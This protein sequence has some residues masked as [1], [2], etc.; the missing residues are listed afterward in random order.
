[1]SEEDKER[2]NDW[3][4]I[5]EEVVKAVEDDWLRIMDEV[6]QAIGY[7]YRS[8]FWLLERSNFQNESILDALI[9][10]YVHAMAEVDVVIKGRA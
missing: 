9:A 7:A 4:P 6:V 2:F 10:L 5:L 1:M 3:I 8:S